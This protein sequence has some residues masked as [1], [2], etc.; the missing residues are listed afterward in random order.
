MNNCFPGSSV[1]HYRVAYS[2]FH[3]AGLINPSAT[4]LNG[5]IELVVVKLIIVEIVVVLVVV[6]VIKNHYIIV[7]VIF[8]IL[9][10]QQHQ[11]QHQQ[12]QQQQQQQH[13]QQQQQQLATSTTQAATIRPPTPSVLS[14]SF[15]YAINLPSRSTSS[16]E[17]CSCERSTSGSYVC[18]PATQSSVPQLVITAGR[19]APA[20]RRPRRSCGRA[21]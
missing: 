16:V 10:Q 18:P 13:Q 19:R 20:A 21:R 1:P 12:Q 4:T 3:V 15:T 17:Y 14:A 8:P 5:A 6:A 2:I 7:I 11:H 9:Q